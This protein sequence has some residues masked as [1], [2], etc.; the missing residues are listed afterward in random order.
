MIN[1]S[2]LKAFVLD[3]GRGRALWHLGALMNFKALGSETGGQYWA[4]EGLADS[5]MAVPLHVHTIEDEI[6]YVLEGEVR[7]IIGDQDLRGGPGTFVY[8]PRGVAH[9]FQVVSATARWFGFGTP[10][11]L[12]QWFFETGEPAGALTLPP[13][14]APPDVQMIVDSLRR[15][16]TETV[17]PPPTLP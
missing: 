12:D 17:G 4:V 8:I 5:R 15:Y 2:Q 14:G 3:K 9:S 10:A 11:G 7:F 6:W 16:G 13:P 1:Q